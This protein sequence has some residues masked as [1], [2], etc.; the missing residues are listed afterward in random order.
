MKWRKRDGSIVNWRRS[1]EKR[2]KIK[3][4]S[5]KRW[6]LRASVHVSVEKTSRSD[7]MNP[8]EYAGHPGK[9]I[10][11][12]VFLFISERTQGGV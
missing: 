6:P 10:S 1:G 5:V 2:R 9:L 7:L 3:E 4:R 8:K 12:I 11:L